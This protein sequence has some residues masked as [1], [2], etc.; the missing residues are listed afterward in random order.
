MGRIFVRRLQIRYCWNR[1]RSKHITIKLNKNKDVI[2]ENLIRWLKNHNKYI[3]HLKTGKTTLTALI[4]QI[5]SDKGTDFLDEGLKNKSVKAY[6]LAQCPKLH[7]S[8]C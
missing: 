3:R 2:K 8:T 1:P 6:L 7:P 5:R 4:E